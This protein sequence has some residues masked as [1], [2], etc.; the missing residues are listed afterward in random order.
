LTPKCFHLPLRCWLCWPPLVGPFP[1]CKQVHVFC[2]DHPWHRYHFLAI[3]FLGLN[4]LFSWMLKILE[5]NC[6]T[7]EITFWNSSLSSLLTMDCFQ[8]VIASYS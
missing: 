4:C 1:Y 3:F 2:M 6:T 5:N 7:N 8:V